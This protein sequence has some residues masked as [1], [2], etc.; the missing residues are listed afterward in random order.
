[1][2]ELARAADVSRGTLY[3]L[4]PGKS[5]LMDGL[6]VEYSPLEAVRQVVAAHADDPPAVVLPLV[7]DAIVG[8]AGVRLGLM[9]AMFT[10]LSA[11][12][13][14]AVA[15]MH[16]GFGRRLPYG[17]IH[18]GTD[19]RRPSCGGCSRSWRSRRSSGRSSF[20]S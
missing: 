10:E 3:R 12:S 17:G 20:T 1:M 13:E 9:R 2:D 5:A 4:F 11:A 6:I 14:A 15:G 16:N 7:A 18:E 8:T 19:A